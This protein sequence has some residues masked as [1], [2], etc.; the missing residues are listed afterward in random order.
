MKSRYTL[1]QYLSTSVHQMS[2][3]LLNTA[4]RDIYRSCLA[5][6]DGFRWAEFTALD[7]NKKRFTGSDY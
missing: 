7:K 2:E 4:P 1:V 3:F 5:M 6:R